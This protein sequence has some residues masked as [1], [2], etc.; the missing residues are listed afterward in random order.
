MNFAEMKAVVDT[1]TNRPDLVAESTFAILK[2]TFELHA[3]DEWWPDRIE[4]VLAANLNP[5]Q[6][7]VIPLDPNLPRLRKIEAIHPF[8]ASFDASGRTATAPGFEYVTPSGIF[9]EFLRQKINY[10]YLAGGNLVVRSSYAGSPLYCAFWRYPLAV[11]AV[12]YASWIADKY[13]FAIIN[14]AAVRVL[15]GCG[16]EEAANGIEKLDCVADLQYLR[17][18]FISNT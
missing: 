14:K 10:F 18:N 7:S 9:D 5:T 2:A 16:S 1:L 11:S 4:A 13:P 6:N 12:Q 17:Q 3:A 15:R 8:D